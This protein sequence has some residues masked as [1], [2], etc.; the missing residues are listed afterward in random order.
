MSRFSYQATKP[1]EEE[2]NMNKLDQTYVTKL[3]TS[4]TIVTILELEIVPRYRRVGESNVDL[5]LIN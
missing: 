5:K 4:I 3:N 1:L 2:S